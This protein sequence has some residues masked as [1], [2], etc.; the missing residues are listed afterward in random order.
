MTAMTTPPPFDPQLAIALRDEHER[1]VTS[2]SP[3]EIP[4]L[5]ARAEHPDAEVL[6]LGGR[7]T[8]RALTVP[9]PAGAPDVPVVLVRPT[10]ATGPV[11]LILHLHGG[12]MVTGNAR[13]DMVPVTELAVAAGCAVASVE[14]RL[15]PEHPYPAAVEDAYAA[16]VWLTRH[17][18]DLGLDAGCVVVEGMSA[19]GGLAAAAALLA[20]DR[21]GPAL[22]GQMLLCPMLDDRND[23]ASGTQMVGLGVWD[24]T[25]NETGWAAY[26]GGRAGGPDVP[27]Y[28]AP[29]RATD[30]TGLPPAF[31]DVGSAETFRDEDVSYAARL[32][33]CGGV[34]ELHVWP[35]GFH[36]FDNLAPTA[37]LSQEARAARAR[38]LRRIL[39]RQAD[40]AGAA[41]TGTAL[42]GTA[43]TGT[44]LTGSE[45]SDR[46]PSM[47]DAR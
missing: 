14:Y 11:P 22:A 44:A 41:P 46:S 32:W 47:E 20:R 39:S 25:A 29:A 21:G 18:E 7:L 35:G 15:A 17:A 37:E 5:R 42:A 23:S 38:W 8:L 2:L 10:D 12:G 28:A 26:L 43:R 1:V 31:I 13:E 34:A 3:D 45:P 6:T 9:G 19:G 36:G 33:A 16:L 27:P 4:A 30:L 24:R 40:V